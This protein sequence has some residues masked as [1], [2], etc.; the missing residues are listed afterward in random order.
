MRRFSSLDATFLALDGSSGAGHICLVAQLDG[1]IGLTRLRD[2]VDSHLHLIPILRQR[3]LKAPLNLAR[4]WWVD[5]PDFDLDRHLVEH[6]LLGRTGPQRAADAIARIASR[7]L[8]RSMP[9]WEIHLLQLGTTGRSTVV[10]KVHH[11]VADGIGNRDLLLTLLGAATPAIPAARDGWAPDPVPNPFEV[12]AR[13][14]LGLADVPGAIARLSGLVVNHL[15]RLGGAVWSGAARAP[16]RT[17]EWLTGPS[18]SARPSLA[19]A[20]RI[21]SAPKITAPPTPFN[22][23]ITWER[24]WAYGSVPLNVS[25]TARR[26]MGVTVNDIIL[27]ATAAAVRAELLAVDALPSQPLRALVPISV[28]PPGDASSGNQI[29]LMTCALPTDLADP[30]ARLLAVRQATAAAK[31]NHAISARTLQDL[32]GLAPPLLATQ[33]ASLIASLRLTDRVRLPFNLIVSNVPGT[34]NTLSCGGR[35]IMTLYP[36]PALGN[37]VGLNITVQ[38]YRDRL[39]IG[40]VTCPDIGSDPWVLLRSMTEAYHQ[41]IRLGGR[42]AT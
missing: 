40:I 11:A 32:A 7:Q 19:S 28:R 36:L 1:R 13:T 39:H 17:V 18:R 15:P 4:P 41:L 27:A 33:A 26:A 3:I 38:G 22:R 10:S 9:L 21:A 31:A 29:E 20:P 30:V 35:R 6:A 25:Q 23:M 8:D 5:D 2:I 14:A 16:S 42:T 34:K 24:R 37:G 12:V